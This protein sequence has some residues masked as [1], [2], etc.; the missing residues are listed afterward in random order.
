MNVF[1]TGGY[2]FE[3]DGRLFISTKN[4]FIID[5]KES[6]GLFRLICRIMMETRAFIK[7]CQNIEKEYGG[8]FATT[9]SYDF[10]MDYNEFISKIHEQNNLFLEKQQRV[11]FGNLEFYSFFTDCIYHGDET[12][13]MYQ[14]LSLFD[15]ETDG[16]VDIASIPSLK[17]HELTFSFGSRVA[18]KEFIRRMEDLGHIEPVYTDSP[19][20]PSKRQGIY[21][22]ITIDFFRENFEYID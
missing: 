11:K 22:G 21:E 5:Y 1:K 4:F 18:E 3:F 13:L 12:N 9:F 20:L 16:M 19:L 14:C 10:E 17:L 2:W 15:P 8:D 6:E 7:I